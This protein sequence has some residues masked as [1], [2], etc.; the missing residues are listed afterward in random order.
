MNRARKQMAQQNG[1][2]QVFTF[3]LGEHSPEKW[4]FD[5]KAGFLAPVK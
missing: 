4:A 2:S 3:T 1:G 5:L